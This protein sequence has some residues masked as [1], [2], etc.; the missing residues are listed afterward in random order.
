VLEVV[1]AVVD[2]GTSLLA[3]DVVAMV[4]VVVVVVGDALRAVGPT[5]SSA[6]QSGWTWMVIEARASVPFSSL[7]W[8]SSGV[9]RP[10]AAR[11]RRRRGRLAVLEQLAR[12]TSAAV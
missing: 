8:D 2:A 10:P 3:A 9:V 12:A 1:L 7:T 6:P 4:V 11:M 5:V